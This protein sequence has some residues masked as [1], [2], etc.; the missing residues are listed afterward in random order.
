MPSIT[1]AVACGLTKLAVP[2][3]TAVAPA[4]MNSMASSPVMIPPMPRMGTFTPLDTCQTMRRATGFT[5]GPERPPTTRASLGLRVRAST[6][7]PSRVLISEMASAPF[8]SAAWAI[9]TTSVTLGE[10]LTIMGFFVASRHRETTFSTLGTWVPIVMPPA[11]TLGQLMLISYAWTRGSS[12]KASIT[13]T[14]SSKECP[15]TFTITG[16]SCF[17]SQ[18]R[19]FSRSTLTPGFC[20][21]MELSIPDAVSAIRGLSLPVQPLR[22]TPLVVT[23]P[24]RSTGTKSLYSRPAAKV[25]EATVTGLR[26]IKP[27]RLTCMFTLAITRSPLQH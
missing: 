4:S 23:A 21:P 27:P 9:S 22:D 12:S 14:Y 2:T 5:A 20:K 10:S 16:T 17:S 1:S 13:C 24:R 8:A 26:M 25:P 3:E 7:M 18:D 19:S 11:S 6:A 15:E